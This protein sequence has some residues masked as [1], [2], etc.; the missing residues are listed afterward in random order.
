M[1]QI[2]PITNFLLR[3]SFAKQIYSIHLKTGFMAQNCLLFLFWKF[4]FWFCTY[5]HLC[6]R[7]ANQIALNNDS[8]H[9]TYKAWLWSRWTIS[10][11][12][13]LS[14]IGYRKLL[15]I[16]SIMIEMFLGRW[17]AFWRSQNGLFWNRKRKYRGKQWICG[18]SFLHHFLPVFWL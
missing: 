10:D 2:T 12:P 7:F 1:I 8:R 6:L 5:K 18:Q 16:F 3:K 17:I 4:C 13:S 9:W 15:T 11:G 14:L